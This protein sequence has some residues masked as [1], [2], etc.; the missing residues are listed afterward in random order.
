MSSPAWLLSWLLVAGPFDAIAP[1]PVF[2]TKVEPAE[3]LRW[4]EACQRMAAKLGP[5][6][7]PWQANLRR[8]QSIEAFVRHTGRSR[9]EAA[10]VVG[11]TIWL[12]PR[13][14]FERIPGSDAIRRHE[15]VHLYLRHL[16]VPPLNPALEEALAIG[17]SGQAARLPAGRQLRAEG[18]RRAGAILAKPKDPAQLRSTLQDVVS[19]LWPRLQALSPRARLTQLRRAGAAKHGLGPFASPPRHTQGSAEP[20]D[21]EE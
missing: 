6:R 13:P 10:A 8:A 7:G 19:T 9:F 18:L 17:L 11:R 14:V 21:A 4:T 2:D 20:R 1:R 15:C 16:G 12:Q 3:T 5:S